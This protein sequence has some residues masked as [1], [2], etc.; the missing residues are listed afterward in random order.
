MISGACHRCFPLLILHLAL[1][2]SHHLVTGQDWLLNSI[3]PSDYDVQQA[4]LESDDDLLTVHGTIWLRR[5][6]A[7]EDQR[8]SKNI[9]ITVPI[10]SL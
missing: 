4:P 2:L 3:I 7:D 5:L 1:I 8:V 9:F 10:F 6:D